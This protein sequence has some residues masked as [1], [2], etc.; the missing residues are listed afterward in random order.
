MYL[1]ELVYGGLDGIITTFVIIAG[2]SGA[3]FSNKVTILLGLASII[4]DGFSMGISSYLAEKM[5]VNGQNPYM[6]GLVTFIA[7]ILLGFIPL[8]PYILKQKINIDNPIFYSSILTAFLLILLGYLKGNIISSLE[9]LLIG[10]FA[11]FLAYTI[12]KQL[13]KYIK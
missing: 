7:F 8:I 12:T 4:A 13:K 3:T 1:S 10:S 6:V 9:T 2:S 11:A 5:R